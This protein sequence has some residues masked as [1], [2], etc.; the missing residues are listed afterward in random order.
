MLFYVCLRWF[1]LSFLGLFY[2]FFSVFF[3]KV[4]FWGVISLW[5]LLYEYLA[6]WC[7]TGGD[8]PFGPYY[9]RP[10]LLGLPSIGS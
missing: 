3:G 9:D 1:S 4:L 7:E 6:K 5:A 8:F 2:G 10:Y